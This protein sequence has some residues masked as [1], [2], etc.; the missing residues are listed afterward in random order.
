MDTVI[1][2]GKNYFP[3]GAL[4][5]TVKEI[6]EERIPQHH[7]D[8]TEIKHRHDFCEL[9]IITK[10]RGAQWIEGRD[11]QVMAGD[12][13]FLQ[14]KQT[15]FFRER[16]Q[17]VHSNI[18]FAQDDLPFP[19]EKLRK[20]SGYQAMFVLEPKYRRRHNFKSKLHLSP[21]SLTHVEGLVALM[22]EECRDELEGFD[23]RL[24]SLLLELIVYLARQYSNTNTVE[25]KALLRV[26]EVIGRIERNYRHS[27]TLNEIVKR[28]NMSKSGLMLVFREATGC[29]PIDYVNKIRLR[30]A[31][32]RLRSGDETI[33]EIAFDV[34]FKD[35]N[36]FSR[37]FRKVVGCSPSDYRR[38]RLIYT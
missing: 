33:G 5:I 19:L 29:T 27:W 35:G 6:K 24:F 8:F 9:V 21:T 28:A 10:G 12:V 22:L 36:Y 30:H 38:K 16:D 11:Y 13:F 7:L 37:L 18:M 25:G 15:H 34:G 14:G 31:M 4:P 23:V 2:D 1:A 20:M 32:E 17:L 26:G 3:T